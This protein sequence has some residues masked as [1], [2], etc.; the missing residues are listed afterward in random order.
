MSGP[1]LLLDAI[2]RRGVLYEDMPVVRST[3]YNW[4]TGEFNR[5]PDAEESS[6]ID[7]II[8]HAFEDFT[9]RPTPTNYV[10]ED[11]VQSSELLMED[12]VDTSPSFFTAL[13]DTDSGILA[14]SGDTSKTTD[15]IIENVK[16]MV[17]GRIDP[18]VS[19]AFEARFRRE[20]WFRKSV[21]TTTSGANQ[22]PDRASR[23]KRYNDTLREVVFG[24]RNTLYAPTPAPFP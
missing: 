6:I 16:H 11:R 18:S 23:A 3:I 21:H 8:E 2:R 9:L 12:A 22:Q 20:K 17:R 4:F 13:Q 24:D 15:Q 7:S 10:V 5:A 14:G 1:F 19:D